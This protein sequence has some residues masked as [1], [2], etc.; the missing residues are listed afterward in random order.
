M[1][2]LI[3]ILTN[4]KTDEKEGLLADCY[5]ANDIYVK[6]IKASG[7]L[8]IGIFT[9]DEE[10]LDRCDGFLLI[11]GNRI[12][13][14]H[15]RIIEYAIKKDK[16]LLGICNGMQA[17]VMYAN[18]CEECKKA[19]IEPT[20]SNL[21]KKYD[22]LKAKNVYFLQKI[23]NHGS[24]LSQ[25][26]VELNEENLNKYRH[27]VNFEKD[28]LLAEYY[29]QTSLNVA[30][31]HTYGVYEV[32]SKVE[33]LA[34]SDDNVVEAVKYKNKPI[35]GIQFHAEFDENLILFEKLIEKCQK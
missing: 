5:K 31:A 33:V 13:E 6:K 28:S 9:S 12:T 23:E 3:G 22:E 25:R 18:L 32:P 27:K 11:G 30:S 14:N 34:R 20:I 7:G 24:E 4:F 8:A 1:K 21:Y 26:K 19:H 16:P 15:Y 2:P 29:N 10:V 35:I 17:I